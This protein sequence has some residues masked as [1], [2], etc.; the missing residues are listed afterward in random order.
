MKT[1]NFARWG[2]LTAVILLVA[3][4]GGVLWA[5]RNF[6]K[7]EAMKQAVHVL[8]KTAIRT[9]IYLNEVEIATRNTE[10]QVLKSLQPDSLLT[11]SRRIV[12][13]NPDLNGCSV[14]MEPGFFPTL[15]HNFSAYSVRNGK[16]IET[17]MEGDYD[18]YSQVWYKQAR[19]AGRPVW[20]DP[21]EDSNEAGS[22]TSADMIAS[23]S[24]PLYKPD[25]KF[26]GVL[27]TDISLPWLSQLI[28]TDPPYEG[29]YFLMTGKSGNFLIHPDDEM[30]VYHSIFE[31][32]NAD[33]GSGVVEL[34]K[35]MV[36]GR[37][38]FQELKLGGKD[39]LVFYQPIP[40]SGWSIAMVCPESS[41]TGRFD[42]IAG[43][44]SVIIVIVLALTVLMYRR[45]A[46]H[47][48][49]G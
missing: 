13:L 39:C 6:L 32:T 31:N 8:E 16:A 30:V 42:L 14:T 40:L 26:V 23:Y 17:V 48:A 19:D 4:A 5:A 24:V 41:I 7:E 22:L 1:N 45:L 28:S 20:V 44:L 29:A 37:Q 49:V 35:A 18:Y 38:G 21:Y 11:Y 46:S 33:A 36:A 47:H 3:I 9:T 27:S 10:W 15:G 34:G 43:V 25:G 12:E 2:T